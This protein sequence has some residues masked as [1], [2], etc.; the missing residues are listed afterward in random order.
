VAVLHGHVR[1]DLA[2]TGG[3]HGPEDVLKAMMAGA[4][5][6]MMTSALLLHG[7]GHLARVRAGLLEWMELHEYTSIRQMQGSMSYRS[8]VDPAAFERANYMKVLSSYAL[9]ADRSGGGE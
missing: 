8:V 6:A 9:R 7:I 2:I 5:V 1:A 3:V 4:R